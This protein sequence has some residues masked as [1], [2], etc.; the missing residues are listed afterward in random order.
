M[1]KQ[2]SLKLAKTVYHSSELHTTDPQPTTF[3]HVSCVASPLCSVSPEMQ[4]SWADTIQTGNVHASADVSC[5]KCLPKNQE[6]DPADPLSA[7][8]DRD[9]KVVLHVN[10]PCHESPTV[11]FK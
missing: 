11:L 1:H 5:I 9:Y 7:S 6:L 8:L 2:L 4:I 10:L 3:V